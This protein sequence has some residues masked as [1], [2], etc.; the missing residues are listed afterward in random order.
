MTIDS[1][2]TDIQKSKLRFSNTR[3]AAP[4]KIKVGDLVLFRDVQEIFYFTGMHMTWC[5]SGI[6]IL[7]SCAKK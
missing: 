7:Q 5:F 2:I 1:V 4:D 6:L 3:I